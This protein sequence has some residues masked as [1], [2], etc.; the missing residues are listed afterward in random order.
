MNNVTLVGRLVRNPEMKTLSNDNAMTTFT[1]AVDREFSREK[2]ADFLRIVVYGK[3]AENC[4]R[5]LA[6][7]S[8]AAVK[9]RIQTGSYTK[10][11]GTKVYTTDIVADR[12][13]FLSSPSKPKDEYDGF[14]EYQD[15]DEDDIPF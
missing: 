7:G 6:K 13:E 1:L 8:Q 9:G 12:V 2:E 4:N 5:Y 3:P 15:D 14:H 11:D 10:Q